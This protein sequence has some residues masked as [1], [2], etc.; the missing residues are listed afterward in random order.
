MATELVF[1]YAK[2]NDFLRLNIKNVFLN[3]II[4]HLGLHADI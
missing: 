3:N 1:F 4:N 2:N